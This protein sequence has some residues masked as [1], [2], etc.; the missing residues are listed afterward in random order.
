MFLYFHEPRVLL[1]QTCY[2]KVIAR[3]QSLLS[4]I[5]FYFYFFAFL[6]LGIFCSRGPKKS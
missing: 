4:M 2:D 3:Y 6:F 5:Y 1:L